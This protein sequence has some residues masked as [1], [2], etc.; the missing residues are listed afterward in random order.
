MNVG[1]PKEGVELKAADK[2]VL[3]L[4]CCSRPHTQEGCQ[5]ES[6]ATAGPGEPCTE[7]GI[8]AA[9]SK[10]TPIQHGRMN[11]LCMEEVWKGRGCFWTFDT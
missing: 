6:L 4:G 5:A 7:P 8:Q 3:T 1:K 11:T 2:S 9:Y 10:E